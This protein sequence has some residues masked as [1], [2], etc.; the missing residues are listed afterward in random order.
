MML[1]L[2]EYL[3]ECVDNG[4]ISSDLEYKNNTI[5]QSIMIPY[6]LAGAWLVIFESIVHYKATKRL[7]LYMMKNI[8]PKSNQD[9]LIDM[10]SSDDETSA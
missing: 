5:A 7:N 6:T 10:F 2:S 8:Y 9:T 1:T 4:K 3:N